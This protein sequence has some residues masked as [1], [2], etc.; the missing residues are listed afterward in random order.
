MSWFSPS[1][2]QRTAWLLSH[3]SA[4]QQDGE[5]NQKEK[6]KLVGWDK[7]SLTERKREKK[8]TTT[9]LIKTIYRVQFFPCLMLSLLPSSKAPCSS[10]LLT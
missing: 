5:E 7:N 6:A 1:W 8:I 9:I 4:P 2:Q 3:S 10:Q